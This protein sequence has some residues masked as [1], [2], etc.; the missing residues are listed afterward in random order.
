MLLIYRYYLYLCNPENNKNQ[1][2]IIKNK[3]KNELQQV[4]AVIVGTG[5]TRHE[6]HPTYR[7]GSKERVSNI[8]ALSNDQLACKNQGKLQ[9]YVQ[10][11]RPR[12]RES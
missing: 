5:F 3:I 11:L 4:S 1:R 12:I 10:D 7:G 2:K 9:Q 8:K 6:L